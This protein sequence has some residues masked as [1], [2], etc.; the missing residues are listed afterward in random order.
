MTNRN[1]ILITVDALRR[2][3]IGQYG[4]SRDT[5]PA[6][7]D[8]IQDGKKF[9]E[10]YS[11]GAYTKVS[12]PSFLTS[13]L[14][15]VDHLEEG[16]T[17]ASAFSEQGFRTLGIHS[18]TWLSHDFVDFDGFDELVD[19]TEDED[20]WSGESSDSTISQIVQ[21]L[22][23][24]FGDAIAQSELLTKIAKR[25]VPSSLRHSATPYVDAE[26][27]T[28]RVINW[29]AENSEQPFFI[30]VHYMDPHRPFGISSDYYLNEEVSQNEIHKLM[31]KAGASP[32]NLTAEEE[33][34]IIDLYDSDIRFMSNHIG[35]LFDYLKSTNIYEDT[36][37]AL[38]ADHGE[39]FGEHG[40]YFHRNKPYNELID[41]P[42][43]IKSDGNLS[44]GIRQLLDIGPTLLNMHDVSIPVSFEGVGLNDENDG[45]PTSIGYI[46]SESHVSV[47]K[48][49]YKL[50]QNINDSEQ[51]ELYN[52]K[53]DRGE[54]QKIE[55]RHILKSL[56]K[57]MPK[58]GNLQVASPEVDGA[59]GS[60]EERLEDL[61]YI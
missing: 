56:R 18:N 61:G 42:L 33:S 31:S 4:Y 9:N 46:G 41:V 52:I 3:H 45:F 8:L 30:W 22:E 58:E 7:E 13:R 12:V 19:F 59:S 5:L 51:Y 39:E 43:I 40:M 53:E 1:T 55:D 23:S 26:K 35:R 34:T 17:I 27:T 49:D 24:K 6:I 48:E 54:R 50:I 16:P 38:T 11:N 28:D 44:D 29:I 60:T 57:H 37:I 21:Q 25:C 20:V 47:V 36:N 15:G 2:D 14:N 10:V 32:Q